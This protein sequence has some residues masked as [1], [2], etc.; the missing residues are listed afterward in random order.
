MHAPERA[1]ASHHRLVLGVALVKPAAVIHR[2]PP[3]QL[4]KLIF[5]AVPFC[6]PG[7]TAYV[8]GGGPSFGKVDPE[9]LRGLNVIA[10]NRSH[11][12]VPF[13]QFQ[14]F[15]DYRFWAEPTLNKE[16]MRFAGQ[17]VAVYPVTYPER[18]LALQR[19]HLPGLSLDRRKVV[20]ENT[21]MATGINFAALTGARRIV[22]MG[23]DGKAGKDGRFHH[24]TPYGWSPIR[25]C[26]DRQRMDLQT[27]T[28]PLEKLGIEVVN[29]SPGSAWQ[30]WPI[31]HPDSVLP[32]RAA[33]ATSGA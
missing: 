23:A 21:V 20:F 6:W 19:K 2:A 14:L 24:H 30:I 7:E 12:V 33:A 4:H 31:V 29:A 32:P 8:I 26:W 15:A 22:L 1:P 18:V 16:L 25:G 17:I 13:A 3:A 5:G 28:G 27:L 9:R 10:L 11:T